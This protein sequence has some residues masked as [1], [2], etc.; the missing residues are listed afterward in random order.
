[1]TRLRGLTSV[2]VAL[3][4]GSLSCGGGQP[5]L[6]SSAS[7]TGDAAAA[8][9]PAPAPNLGPPN[10]VLILADDLGWG[11]LGSYG[12]RTIH[13]PNLDRLAAEGAR[14]T[15]FYVPSPICAPSRAGLLTGRFPPRV[16]I[17]WNPPTRL[18]DGEVV[19]AKVLKAGGYATGMVGKWHL[20]NTDEFMPWNHGFD[21]FFG[22]PHSN[23]EK[24]FFLFDNRHRLPET[25][26]QIQLIR[27][28]TERAL[29]FL[30]RAA[31]PNE[32]FFLYL[33][34]NAPHVP[35]YPSAGFSGR[36]RH[37][38]YGDVVE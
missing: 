31:R 28:Y 5:V 25:V 2:V 14:F 3:L 27:R 23:D 17:P 8:A 38:T 35:L 13:T 24:N 32:P 12:N 20:G 16:G 6:P 1:M 11:D 15:S 36:S 7:K 9:V 18:H 21:E 29:E 10:V 37:G 34:Y 4:S 19:L 22:V 33:A 26:D 30:G